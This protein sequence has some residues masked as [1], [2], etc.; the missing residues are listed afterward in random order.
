MICV[1]ARQSELEKMG[2]TALSH[3]VLAQMQRIE[4]LE[5]IVAKIRRAQYGAKSERVPLNAD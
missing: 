4:H 5:F 2:A 3:L 1:H